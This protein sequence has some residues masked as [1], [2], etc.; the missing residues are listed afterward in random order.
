MM[1]QNL[2]KKNSYF[3]AKYRP[4]GAAQVDVVSN[5]SNAFAGHPIGVSVDLWDTRFGIVLLS[6][7][8]KV[9]H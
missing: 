7:Y 1:Y 9:V 4:K 2:M 8:L 6:L 5:G 3:L